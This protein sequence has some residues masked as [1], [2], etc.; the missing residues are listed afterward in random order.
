MLSWNRRPESRR[1][2]RLLYRIKEEQTR[3]AQRKI[4]RPK[5]NE[6]MIVIYDGSEY[7]EI[8]G[9][10]IEEK[11]DFSIELEKSW[12][13]MHLE[14]VPRPKVNEKMIVI[15]DGS[16]HCEIECQKVDK[17]ADSPIE[18]G[19]NRQLHREKVVRPKEN[20]KIITVDDGFEYCETEG[21]AYSSSWN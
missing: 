13:E 10:K 18:L 15:D 21:G 2:S 1:E 5:V 6:K 8:E 16:E 4:A 7:C 11:V 17:K 12:Q 14:K 20:E 9:Q 3:T 19:K